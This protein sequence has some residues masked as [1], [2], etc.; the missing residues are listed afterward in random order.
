MI[1][2]ERHEIK[3]DSEFTPLELF[4]HV[5]NDE[6]I[7]ELM[8]TKTMFV[9]YFNNLDEYYEIFTSPVRFCTVNCYQNYI[10]RLLYIDNKNYGTIEII[11]NNKLSHESIDFKDCVLKPRV[12]RGG[13]GNKRVT[14]ITFDLLNIK[15]MKM[16][17]LMKKE[18]PVITLCGS[19]KFKDEFIQMQKKLSLE[20]NV[21]LSLSIFS[22]VENPE[23]L[24][25]E[26]I[27]DLLVSEQYQKIRMCDKI[28][29][30]NKN[31]YIGSSTQKEIE[32][33]LSL[34]KEVLYME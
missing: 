26:K 16:Q 31:G 11:D 10:G 18:F 28:Y 25:D 2:F 23:L 9:E 27:V 6:R 29:V 4:Y 30:I 19:T 20:G 14:I 7:Q 22:H 1:N 32:Y 3:I 15:N 34:G 17:L 13:L 5:S 24:N 21:V 8:K 33:A 12:L